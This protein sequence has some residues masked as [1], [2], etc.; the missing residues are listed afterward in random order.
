MRSTMIVALSATGLLFGMTAAMAQKAPQGARPAAPKTEPKSASAGDPDEKAIRLVADA[1]AKAYNAHDAKA[2]ANLFTPQGELVDEEGS[3]KQGRSAIEREFTQ[4]FETFPQA[5]ISISIKSV[6]LISP[7]VAAEDGSADVIREPGE[8][9]GLTRY[10]V[11]HVKQDGKWLIASTRDYPDESMGDHEL[12]QL[13]WL[14]GDWIDESP[15]GLVKTSYRWADN[16]RYILSD[17]TVQVGGRGVM[18]GSQRI[19]WDP[20]AKVVRSWVFDSE[21]G[22]ADGN[23]SRDGDQWIV[24]IAGVTRDGKLASATNI[25]TR[26]GKDHMTWQSRDRM[27]DGEATPDI[28]PVMVVRKPPVPQSKLSAAP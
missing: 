9:G 19:G 26:A 17:F 8:A 25:I 6:R 12:Q 20:L 22:F 1:F 23:Y 13:D 24:K 27:V 14:I 5:K 3:V 18:T 7:N 11:V 15:D 21:G 10:T 16:H 2:I 28:D 4:I